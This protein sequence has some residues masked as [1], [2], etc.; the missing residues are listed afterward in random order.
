MGLVRRISLLVKQKV[1]TLL[2]RFEDPKEVLDYSYQKQVEMLTKLRQNVAEVVAA[3]KRLEMQKARLK[4]NIYKLEE[5]AMSA[6]KIGRE[7]LAR[8][9]LERK[10]MNIKQLIDVEK[11]IEDMEREQVRL[12]DLT[13]RLSVK[14]EQF[15]LQKEVMKAK[16][17]AAEAEV[18]IKESVT[19]IAE[20]MADVGYAMHRVEEKT[21]RMKARALALDELM[22]TGVLT[23]YTTNKDIIEKELE[24]AMI[25]SS[26]DK[27]L[28]RMKASLN[29]G[30]DKQESG[31]KRGMEKKEEEE[32]EVMEYGKEERS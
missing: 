1:N 28:E 16:Y 11:Q 19:G 13:K 17:T 4:D 30:M 21:E 29:D 32:G 23:D 26:V 15:K 20:E 9:A 8:L 22:E 3:K 10:N 27:E 2:D 25:K 7:D 14:V 31:R 18:K 5:Q 24:D 12:E 6:L